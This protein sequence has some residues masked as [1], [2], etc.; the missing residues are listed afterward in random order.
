MWGSLQEIVEQQYA[1]SKK[2]NIGILETNLMPDF[3]R[4]I[5][6]NLLMRDLA[7]EQKA[8]GKQ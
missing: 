2:C 1:L 6:V 8:L 3:E 5:H 7:E 4:Q